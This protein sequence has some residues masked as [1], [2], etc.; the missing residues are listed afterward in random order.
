MDREKKFDPILF[1]IYALMILIPILFILAI[2]FLLIP[3]G[4]AMIG[5]VVKN[6]PAILGILIVGVFLYYLLMFILAPIMLLIGKK[7]TLVSLIVIVGIAVI[8]GVMA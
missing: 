6:I 1:T 2:K 8:Y 4:F 7:T 5:F 3:Y